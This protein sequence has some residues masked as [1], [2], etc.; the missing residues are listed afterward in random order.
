MGKVIRPE[1]F[2]EVLVRAERRSRLEQHNADA[3][4]GQNFG[5]G[6]AGRA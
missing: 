2:F 5:G 6:A 4:L 3:A 1:M